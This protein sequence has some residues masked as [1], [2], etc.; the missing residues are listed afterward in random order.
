MEREPEQVERLLAQPVVWP[1]ELLLK[2]RWRHPF[3]Y[4]R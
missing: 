2:V 4:I 1:G 3:F